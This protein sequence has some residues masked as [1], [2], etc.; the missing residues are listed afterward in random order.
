MHVVNLLIIRQLFLRYHYTSLHNYNT[1]SHYVAVFQ[2]ALY[3]FSFLLFKFLA[4]TRAIALRRR[5]ERK[6]YYSMNENENAKITISRSVFYIG[7]AAVSLNLTS[8][9]TESLINTSLITFDT[10]AEF[11]AGG[12]ANESAVLPAVHDGE[13]RFRNYGRS[14]FRRF[15]SPAPPVSRVQHCAARALHN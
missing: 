8:V 12:N 15:S 7:V 11:K 13:F 10:H 2:L 1:F 5:I 9:G 14:S 4:N 6:R 3:I